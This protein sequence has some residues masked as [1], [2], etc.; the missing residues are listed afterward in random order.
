MKIYNIVWVVILF[1]F[2]SCDKKSYNEMVFVEGGQFYMGSND[3]DSDPDEHDIRLVSVHDFFISRYE[4][5]QSEWDEIMGEDISFFHGM[6]LPVECV[7][8]DDAI[9]FIERLNSKTGRHFRLPTE[10]EWEYA[11]HGGKFVVESRYSGS[12][13]LTEVGWTRDNARMSTHRVG[14]LRPNALGLY[15]MTGNVFEWCDGRYDSIY[16]SLDTLMNKEYDLK[17]IRIFKGGCFISHAKHCRNANTNY[18][19]RETKSPTIGFRLAE[20]VNN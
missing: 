2:A 11:A 4:V 20:D 12:D 3:E 16:Y 17:D 6:N 7:S 19:T 15:D 18:N 8:W 14:L 10:S 5:T 13:S 1:L 9:L